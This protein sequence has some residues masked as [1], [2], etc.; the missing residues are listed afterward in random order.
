MEEL[1]EDEAGGD[2]EER[3]GA[4]VQVRPSDACIRKADAAERLHVI[5]QETTASMYRHSL[6]AIQRIRGQ[7]WRFWCLYVLSL[8]LKAT[9]QHCIELL[10]HFAVK[11][12]Q[13]AAGNRQ[14]RRCR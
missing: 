3:G 2:A 1:L 14:P 11:E 12:T 9:V 7:P 10:L 4:E 13:L 5:W 8:R 6:L